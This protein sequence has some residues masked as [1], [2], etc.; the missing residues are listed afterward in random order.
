M[1]ERERDE[2]T[3]GKAAQSQSH[4]PCLHDG[5]LTLLL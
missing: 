1:R 3:L 4:G 2:L 5:I